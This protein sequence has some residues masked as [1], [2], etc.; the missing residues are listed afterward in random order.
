MQNSE[1]AK[2]KISRVVFIDY[3]PAELKLNKE[4]IIVY[5]SKN[6]TTNKLE[7]IRLRVPTLNSKTDRLKLAKLTVVAIN[8]K[9]AS[10]WSPFLEQAGTTYK[11]FDAAVEDFLNS[12]KKQVK[13]NVVRPDTLRTYN[14]NLNMLRQ[15]IAE[16]QLKVVFAL[17]LK[18]KFCV[19]YLDHLQ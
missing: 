12:I 13:D 5:Y 10:G 18:K 3:K 7:R 1:I 8:L 4:W 16:K 11:T 15:Y 9:L 14:S 19:N 17:E 6:P 2:G